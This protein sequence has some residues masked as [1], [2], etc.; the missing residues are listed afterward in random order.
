VHFVIE[1]TA[2]LVRYL[3][4]LGTTKA[5]LQE[6]MEQV[7]DATSPGDALYGDA[8]ESRAQ[9]EGLDSAALLRR[10]VA[11]FMVELLATTVLEL[12]DRLLYSETVILDSVRVALA[13]KDGK[14]P[15]TP[16]VIYGHPVWF[17][18]LDR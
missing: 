8:L 12:R 5:A 16:T 18:L 10:E 4:R 3:A 7:A 2:N 17:S 1:A 11:G 9:R 6:A 14:T 15:P 13:A